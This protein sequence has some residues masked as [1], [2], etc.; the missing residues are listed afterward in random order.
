M[1][2]NID[3]VNNRIE[4]PIMEDKDFLNDGVK[5]KCGICTLDNGEEII[6]IIV[7]LCYFFSSEKVI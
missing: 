5:G 6:G 2:L 3:N 7:E 4:I 1:F